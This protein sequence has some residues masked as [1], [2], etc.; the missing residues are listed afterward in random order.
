[1]PVGTPFTK[2]RRTEGWGARVLLEGNGYD[3][4]YQ[5]ALTHAAKRKAWCSSTRMTIR[6]SSR[7]RE[8]W[9]WKCWRR[10]P[11]LD[12]LIVPI[13]GGGLIAGMAIAAK[14]IKPDISVYRRAI[15]SRSLR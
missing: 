7:G 6:M 5:A 9:R 4:A 12:A 14:A 11:T 13:G 15:S 10:C 2:V 3:A 8:R 1:M